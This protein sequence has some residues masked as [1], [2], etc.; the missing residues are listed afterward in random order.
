MDVHL[1]MTVALLIRWQS[2]RSNSTAA[3]ISSGMQAT[4]S[5]AKEYRGSR[6]RWNSGRCPK[7]HPCTAQP[8]PSDADGMKAAY[9]EIGSIQP[10]LEY[11]LNKLCV[12]AA[13]LFRQF[14]EFR[15]SKRGIRRCGGI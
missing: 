12:S 1:S 8:A 3:V 13:I 7:H 14:R 6:G 2:F 5:E 11:E 9:A 4:V 10:S 15:A